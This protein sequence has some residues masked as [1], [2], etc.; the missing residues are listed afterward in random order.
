MIRMTT[1]EF[2][3]S[4]LLE[5]YVMGLLEDD[6]ATEVAKYIDSNPSIKDAYDNMQETIASMAIG[7]GIEPPVRNK[8]AIIRKMNEKGEN[9]T[10]PVSKVSW[11]L[12]AV[13]IAAAVFLC[14]SVLSMFKINSLEQLI[15][16]Q[17]ASYAALDNDCELVRKISKA[18]E[19]QLAFYTHHATRSKELKG[20]VKGE[21]FMAVAFYNN[22]SQQIAFDIVNE[23]TLPNGKCLYL[24]GDLNGEMIKITKVDSEEDTGILNFDKN[25]ASLNITIEDSAVEIDHPDVSQLIASVNI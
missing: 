1:D 24:W 2:L 11:L 23:A 25:M 5:Q 17:T 7:Y 9:L 3:T 21:N 19:K 16:S 10:Q 12:P 18:Q 13:G 22:M 14:L 6:K 15:E 4:G 20:T 8:E